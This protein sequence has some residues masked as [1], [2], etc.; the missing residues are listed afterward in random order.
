MI[1]LCV[2]VLEHLGGVRPLTPRTPASAVTLGL[3]WLAL[4]LVTL[5]FAGRY[6][7]FVYVDF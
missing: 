4:L 3:W 1:E 5:L 6:S 7:K 2:R